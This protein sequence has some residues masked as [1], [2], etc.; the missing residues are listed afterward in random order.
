MAAKRSSH[1]DLLIEIV[2]RLSRIE[3][4]LDDHLA[5]PAVQRDMTRT[6]TAVI[7]ACVAACA[8]GVSVLSLIKFIK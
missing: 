4:K 5:A 7:A 8:L 2:D 6:A 3:T 1:G